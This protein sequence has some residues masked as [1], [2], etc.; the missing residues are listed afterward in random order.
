M[1]FTQTTKSLPAYRYLAPQRAIW[2]AGRRTL[3]LYVRIWTSRDKECGDGPMR[4]L[5]SVT[6]KSLYRYAT[7]RRKEWTRAKSTVEFLTVGTRGPARESRKQRARRLGEIS[8]NVLRQDRRLLVFPAISA[9]AGLFLGAISFAL[10]DR[11]IGGGHRIAIL[12]ATLIVSYPLTFVT[13]FA[14]VAVAAML[15]ARLNGQDASVSVGWQAARER[16]GAIVIWSLF[17]C[18]V[19]AVLRLLEEFV[20]FGGKLVL[21][22]LD[23]SWSIATLFAVPV[24]AYENLGP[25]ATLRRS[26]KLFR[27]RWGEQTAGAV[28]IGVLAN[29][30]AFPAALMLFAGL[31][32][33]GAIGVALFACGGAGLIAL[34]AFST[35][36]NE[37]YRVFLYRSTLSLESAGGNPFPLPFAPEDLDDSWT[38]PPR[39]LPDESG[40]TR[41]KRARHERAQLPPRRF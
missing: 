18:T 20:P 5:L 14:G 13:T 7:C 1:T 15:A 33:G 34:G 32:L 24:L 9:L 11:L 39:R 17:V 10:A 26:A 38:P 4:L 41:W 28:T 30:V 31:A 27:D 8:W 2:C 6:F 3:R 12:I 40:I 19:G 29:V 16:T 23:F 22:L 21:W 36:L 37:V 25:F 35:A